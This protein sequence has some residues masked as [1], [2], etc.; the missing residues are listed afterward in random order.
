MTEKNIP[1][2]ARILGVADSYD[3]MTSNRS[4]R[5]ALSQET[6]REEIKKGKGTQFDPEMA[7]IMLQ[8]IEEDKE[9]HLR[10]KRSSQKTVLMIDDDP[11]NIKMVELFMKDE[12]ACKIVSASGGKEALRLL[13]E[14]S[15][16]LIVLDVEMPE[17]NG[18]ETLSRIRES[19]IF[20]LFL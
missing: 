13:D 9:Y 8:M 17:M 15:V 12:P 4:Y 20:P 11:I 1:E 3:A 18:F 6:A 14:I 16:Q 5:D 2:M 10:E 19:M 7:D